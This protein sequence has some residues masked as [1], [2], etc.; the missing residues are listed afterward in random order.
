MRHFLVAFL[1][2]SSFALAGSC[3]ERLDDSLAVVTERYEPGSYHYTARHAEIYQNV[4]ECFAEE[5][6][7]DK[8]RFYYTEAGNAYVK[9][10]NALLQDFGLKAGMFNSAGLSYKKAGFKS[11]AINNYQ[12]VI[13]LYNRY[14]NQV[15]PDSK[16]IAERG[17]ESIKNPSTGMIVR[18]EQPQT[19]FNLLYTSMIAGLIIVIALFVYTRV[20]R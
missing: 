14:P 5:G 4:A 13:N 20:G 7:N 18:S 3:Q 17:L 16:T 12:K 2:L 11:Q 9:A 15:P 10:G 1:L 6:K 8:S 19:G